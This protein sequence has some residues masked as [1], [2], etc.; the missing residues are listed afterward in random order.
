MVRTVLPQ[1]A[2]TEQPI[3]E[4]PVAE[5][6]NFQKKKMAIGVQVSPASRRIQHSDISSLCSLCFDEGY[7][8]ANYVEWSVGPAQK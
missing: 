6:E 2:D 7:C 5:V 3:W 1:V 4:V 8:E